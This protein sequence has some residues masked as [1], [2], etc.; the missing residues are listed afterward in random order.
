MNM[1]KLLKW[2]KLLQQAVERA[3]AEQEKL[4][5]EAENRVKLAEYAL[6]KKN[7]KQKLMK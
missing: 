2:R 5:V 1:R 6:K 4:K 3:K 7:Y